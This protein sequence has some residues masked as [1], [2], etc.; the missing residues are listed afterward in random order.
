MDLFDAYPALRDLSHPVVE[1]RSLR[2]IALAALAYDREGYYFAL[3]EPRYWIQ[4]AGETAIGLGGLQ[5]RPDARPPFQTL[6]RH[7]R[8]VWRSRVELPPAEHLY[9]LWPEDEE[10]VPLEGVRERWGLPHLL[11]LT[12]PR[13]G[14]EPM[15][16]ALVQAVYF[17][18]LRRPPHAARP[19]LKVA[20]E[21]L[22]TFLSRVEPWPVAELRAA[23]WATLLGADRLPDDGKLRPILA[24]RALQRLHHAALFPLNVERSR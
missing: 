4:R 20:H 21:A 23:P 19:L 2:L 22:P 13:L 24:L 16:D 3:S 10:V 7:L 14:G 12:P 15:P 9:L 8:Q 5:T 6:S 11:L 1:G 18:R 17:L